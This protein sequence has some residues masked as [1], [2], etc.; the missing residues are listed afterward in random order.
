MCGIAGY[1]SKEIGLG[2]ATLH[3]FTSS[4]H[5]RGPDAAA[6]FMEDHVGLAHNRLSIQDTSTNANQPFVSANGRY[7]MV[8]NGEVYNF[9][10]LRAKIDFPLR[11]TSDTEVI[12]ELFAIYKEKCVDFF[13]GMFALAIYDRQDKELWLMRDRLGI[14]PLYYYQDGE[15]FLFASELKALADLPYLKNKLTIDLEAVQHYLYLGLIPSPSTL[16]Q[17]IKKLDSGSVGKISHKHGLQ[18]SYYWR[19]QDFLDRQYV[20]PTKAKETI[21]E[22]LFDS[23]REHL[24]SDVP[25]G[26]FLSGGI[27]SSLLAAVAQQV[28]PGSIKTFTIGFEDTKYDE[29][30]FAKEIARFLGTDHS[31]HYLHYDHSVALLQKVG[32]I[33]DE[34]FADTSAVPTLLVSQLAAQQVK[35]VLS[36]EGAD[37][38]FLGYGSHVWA[39]RLQNK[40]LRWLKAPVQMLSSIFHDARLQ[41]AA[42]ILSKSG[43][44][45]QAANIYSLEHGFFQPEEIEKIIAQPYKGFAFCKDKNA[46]QDQILFE[47]DLALKDGLLVKMDRATMHHSIEA[48]VPYLDHRIVE[49]ALSLTT[50]QKI[51]GGAKYLLKEILFEMIPQNYFNR[52]KWGFGLAESHALRNYLDAELAQ[53]NIKQP[54]IQRSFCLYNLIHNKYYQ[55]LAKPSL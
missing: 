43:T 16:F 3:H 46:L 53:K 7:V 30:P 11:S 6:V 31:E 29:A 50:D 35:V 52:K 26:L 9:K 10:E 18:T 22:L 44:R 40:G 17:Q 24:I 20:K 37:E 49:F 39:N 4:Q 25:V 42:A 19:A 32:N 54:N 2:E 51:K 1:I 36:G 21:K 33:Y 23:V 27:D 8:Y 55:T 15:H 45:Y 48:R 28:Q 41:K 5:H 47:M 12:L 14:K 34:P 38:L 13:R